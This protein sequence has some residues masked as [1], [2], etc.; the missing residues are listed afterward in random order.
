ME[1]SLEKKPRRRLKSIE[2]IHSKRPWQT[3]LGA[4]GKASLDNKEP[5]RG[6]LRFKSVNLSTAALSGQGVVLTEVAKGRSS[7]D[8]D[9]QERET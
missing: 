4:A 1:R 8:F 9:P 7:L 5:C 3:A 2:K 6:S